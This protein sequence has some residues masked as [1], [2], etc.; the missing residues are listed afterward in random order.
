MLE[1]FLHSP[2]KVISWPPLVRRAARLRLPFWLWAIIIGFVPTRLL[3][4]LDYIVVPPSGLG[5]YLIDTALVL[6]IFLVYFVYAIRFISNRLERLNEYVLQMCPDEP[7]HC[8]SI[9]FRLVNFLIVM[10]F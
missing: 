8:L 3:A 6:S 9:P 1:A 2:S 4:T 10:L 7:L 5:G